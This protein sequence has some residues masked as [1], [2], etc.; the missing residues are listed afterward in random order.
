[1]IEYDITTWANYTQVEKY[2]SYA[3]RL[4]NGHIGC[5]Y[6]CTCSS[7]TEVLPTSSLRVNWWIC[8]HKDVFPIICK[9]VGN[10]SSCEA[11][12]HHFQAD[13]S[14]TSHSRVLLIQIYI[15]QDTLWAYIKWIR[16][17]LGHS[18]SIAKWRRRHCA[19]TGCLLLTDQSYPS[20]ECVVEPCFRHLKEVCFLFFLVR[21]LRQQNVCWGLIK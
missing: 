16:T 2:W 14:L 13:L 12:M 10:D 7:S 6:F 18:Q 8:S 21:S 3:L 17:P 1:M 4:K 20:E 15:W 19:K 11:G 5:L 9:A